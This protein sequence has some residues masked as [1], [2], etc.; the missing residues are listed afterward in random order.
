M[1]RLRKI[2]IAVFCFAATA[3]AASAAPSM[4]VT[5]GG[6]GNVEPAEIGP[7]IKLKAVSLRPIVE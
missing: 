7:P 1:L 3:S 6:T 5:G 2:V 4:T